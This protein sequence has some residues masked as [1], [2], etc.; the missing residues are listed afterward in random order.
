MSKVLSVR[1]ESLHGVNNK[2]KSE[3]FVYLLAAVILLLS[4]LFYKIRHYFN[5]DLYKNYGDDRVPF[6]KG[7]F[8]IAMMDP[9]EREGQN[10]FK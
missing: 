5:T 4:I 10:K 6:I 7:G 9:G 1:S 2:N 8:S 3:M